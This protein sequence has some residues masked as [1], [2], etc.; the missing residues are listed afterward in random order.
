MTVN[1]LWQGQTPQKNIKLVRL[2]VQVQEDTWEISPV[3]TRLLHQN[4]STCKVPMDMGPL[5]LPL[6]PVGV[7]PLS[8]PWVGLGFI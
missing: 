4:S 3:T 8:A 2:W 5:L 1:T 6:N 7:F